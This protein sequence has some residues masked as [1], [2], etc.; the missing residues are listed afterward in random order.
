MTYP[1]GTENVDIHSEN[2]NGYVIPNGTTFTCEIDEFQDACEKFSSSKQKSATSFT[3]PVLR[4]F[5]RLNPNIDSGLNSNE[6]SVVPYENILPSHTHKVTGDVA[7][8]NKYMLSNITLTYP[9]SDAGLLPDRVHVKNDINGTLPF[10]I[11]NISLSCT[12]NCDVVSSDHNLDVESY[13]TH[14]KIPSLI[15]IG[16]K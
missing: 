7:N 6:L 15:Y 1:D 8:P 4:D 5:P 9:G 10:K 13:P 14:I 3:V 11:K 2:F 12:L 16:Q